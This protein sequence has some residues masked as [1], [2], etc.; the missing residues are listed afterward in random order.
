MVAA[1]IA[2]LA[3]VAQAPPDATD[4]QI[5]RTDG[6]AA[7]Q[8]MAPALMSGNDGLG[9]RQVAQPRLQLDEAG[10]RELQANFT[11]TQDVLDQR[12]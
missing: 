1:R 11:T 5:A 7:A 12:H 2:E 10:E 4:D 8:P 9:V 6:P 3:R